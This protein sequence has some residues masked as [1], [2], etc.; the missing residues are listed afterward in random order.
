MG[1]NTTMQSAP[2]MLAS[3]AAAYA[4]GGASTMAQALAGAGAMT[5]LITPAE[6]VQGLVS[7]DPNI[8]KLTKG[9]KFFRGTARG[10]A[11]GIPEGLMGPIGLT[12]GKVITSRVKRTC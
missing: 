6:Y 12:G 9:E 11:E 10:L 1:L 7:D 3:L 8:Q 2:L 4:T 5:A